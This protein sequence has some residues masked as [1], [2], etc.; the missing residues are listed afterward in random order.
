MR[1]EIK[2]LLH[3]IDREDRLVKRKSRKD[4]QDASKSFR[5]F[6]EGYTEAVTGVPQC[7]RELGVV[8]DMD[9]VLLDSTA[10]HSQAFR[11][12]L[13]PLGMVD[14]SY[15]RF[16]GWRTPD[17]FRTVFSET[18][19]RISE[20]KIAECSTKKS[21]RS[22]ELLEAMGHLFR[23]S[24]PLVLKLSADYALALASSGSRRS[25]ETFLEKSGLRTAFQTVVT[26]DD[27]THA[28]PNPEIFMRAIA[29][30][31]LA[32]ACCV[33]VEDAEAGI[34]AACAAGAIAC[35]FGRDS[36]G[37]LQQAGAR[38]TIRSL[39]EL[40]SLLERLQLS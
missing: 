11:E 1:R 37:V 24:A 39:N 23:E 10:C 21:A 17:V 30:L 6:R 40:P 36:A 29:G 4:S 33:V 5:Y 22:R 20:E 3:S 12:I 35:G 14:F 9:G 18:G 32:P 16:A 19:L 27:V 15:S 31:H 8:F 13:T 34:Q 26:G 28:K 38:W 2:R 25:V 7:C